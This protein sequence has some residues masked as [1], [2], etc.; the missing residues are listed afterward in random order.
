[1][2]FTVQWFW[3]QSGG[4]D[5][6]YKEQSMSYRGGHKGLIKTLQTE[7]AEREE[8]DDND[9][10]L[11]SMREEG[12]DTWNYVEVANG[13]QAPTS[14]DS[15]EESWGREWDLPNDLLLSAHRAWRKG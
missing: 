9:W 15:I 1:V 8:T 7:H 14:S 11:S 3:S 2:E 6:A 4:V 12:F 10:G 5:R 13:Q